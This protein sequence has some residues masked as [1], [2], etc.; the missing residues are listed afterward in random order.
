MSA[1]E[2]Q[3]A[4]VKS[5]IDVQLSSSSAGAKQQAS[6]S[7]SP[8]SVIEEK[9]A[10]V[11]SAIDEAVN[12]VPEQVPAVLAK[13]SAPQFAELL[14]RSAKLITPSSS[15]QPTSG[16]MDS[17]SGSSSDHLHH[18]ID[19]LTKSRLSQSATVSGSHSSDMQSSK[20]LGLKSVLAEETK[21]QVGQAPGYPSIDNPSDLGSSGGK[22]IY[23]RKKRTDAQSKGRSQAQIIRGKSVLSSSVPPAPDTS[24]LVHGVPAPGSGT[25]TEYE[26]NMYM[27]F[28]GSY[29]RTNGDSH[30]AAPPARGPQ[31]C[32][33]PTLESN[34]KVT[35]NLHSMH[36]PAPT[37]ESNGRINGEH[38]IFPLP[39]GP[40]YG[41]G[42]SPGFNGKI[43]GGLQTTFPPASAYHYDPSK[44]SMHPYGYYQ[45]LLGS[46][47]FASRAYGSIP[48][49]AAHKWIECD[50]C[51]VTPIVGPRYKSIV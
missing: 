49:P 17:S 24:W 30:S 38:S 43:N 32:R 18:M 3:L 9:L 21:S 41:P 13:L 31:Y 42:T 10:Q 1:V 45:D 2:E 7:R 33:I 4:Q 12:F 16:L 37:V 44:F 19:V 22:L 25:G 50:G 15:V 29:G 5:A 6:D 51:G 39:R 14:D 47:G 26:R 35:N 34:R 20:A 11:K 40:V 36:C 8:M 27:P 46:Y 23:P 48:Q 28:G